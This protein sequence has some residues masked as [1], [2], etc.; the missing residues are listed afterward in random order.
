MWLVQLDLCGESMH[1]GALCGTLAKWRC[2]LP[3][4]VFISLRGAYRLTDAGLRALAGSA[5]AL[6][7][8]NIS[9][10]NL[11]TFDG[12]V[13]PIRRLHLRELYIVHCQNINALAILLALRKLNCPGSVMGC[14]V[15]VSLRQILSMHYKNRVGKGWRSSFLLIV[16]KVSYN[17]IWSSNHY[18]Y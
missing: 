11:V 9:E 3:K 15:T 4:L 12:V 5:L 7:Y 10:S 2:S 1:G 13:S 18:A 16:C 14:R 6:E 8:V 17:R